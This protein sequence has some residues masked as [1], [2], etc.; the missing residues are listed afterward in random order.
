MS[1]RRLPLQLM[2]I[3]FTPVECFE[4]IYPWEPCSDVTMSGCRLP[5]QF[6]TTVFT[7]VKRFE[8]ITP[9]NH[10]LM[11][12]CPSIGCHC[13]LWPLCLLRQNVLK[14]LRL[15]TMLWWHNVWVS[16]ATAVYDHCVYSGRTFWRYLPLRTMLWWHNV[17]A[18]AATAAY[19]HCVY[20]GITFWRYLPR[21]PCSDDTM[22]ERRLPLQLMTTVFTPVE[23]FEDTSS[24]NHALMTQCPSVS[25]HC[26]LR[27]LCLLE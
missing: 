25:C 27:P 3:V 26:S 7:Q 22:S 1:E 24:E 15:R 6:T 23:R 16:A 11:T 19:D 4:D 10:A 14:I 8:D 21:D 12:Q 9:E 20:S 17:R 13:S 5:M 2:T 18:S